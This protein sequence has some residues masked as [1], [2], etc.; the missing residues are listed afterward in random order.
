METAAIDNDKHNGA[1]RT[2]SSTSF[3]VGCKTLD[4]VELGKFIMLLS[5]QN[6]L[7]YFTS[8]SVLSAFIIRQCFKVD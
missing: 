2:E 8:H 7:L 3:H 4:G 1:F 6:F 5:Y